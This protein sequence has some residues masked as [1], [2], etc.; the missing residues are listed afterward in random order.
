[1][2]TASR[3]ALQL[4]AVRRSPFVV[5]PPALALRRDPPV[6]HARSRRSRPSAN[7]GAHTQRAGPPTSHTI[8]GRQGRVPDPADRVQ[9][10]APGQDPWERSQAPK[11]LANLLVVSASNLTADSHATATVRENRPQNLG[12]ASGRRA[13][14]AAS[15]AA[16][17]QLATLCRAARLADR[18]RPC[19]PYLATAAA[20]GHW[21]VSARA[22]PI[23]PGPALSNSWRRG[24]WH[25]GGEQM[26]AKPDARRHPDPVCTPT[27]WQAV[28]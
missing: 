14:P 21:P 12:H 6:G 25:S 15:L 16:P 19:L 1:V 4:A 9:I 20:H 22:G 27:R 7:A 5:H 13:S 8:C 2:A 3:S 11:K 18:T 26:H 10:R 28:S 17:V 24:L 23:R